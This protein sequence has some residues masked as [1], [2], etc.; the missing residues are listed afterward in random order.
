MLMV[1]FVSFIIVAVVIM[2]DRTEIPYDITN[3]TTTHHFTE[4]DENPMFEVLH[5]QQAFDTRIGN[6]KKYT[7]A[8]AIVIKYLLRNT[9]FFAFPIYANTGIYY[10]SFVVPCGDYE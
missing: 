6:R 3:T 10:S 8:D 5:T 7:K 4:A 2:T 9:C 1:P